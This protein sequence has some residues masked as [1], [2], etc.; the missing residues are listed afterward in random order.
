MPAVCNFCSL[1][2]FS[3]QSFWFA[4]PI[5]WSLGVFRQDYKAQLIYENTI[6]RAKLDGPIYP[7]LEYRQA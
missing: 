7:Q 6:L 5:F 4:M 1:R 3:L 2:F